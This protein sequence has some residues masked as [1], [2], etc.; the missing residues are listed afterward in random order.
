MRKGN[1]GRNVGLVCILFIMLGL[2]ATPLK[3]VTVYDPWNFVENFQAA[4]QAIEHNTNL[5]RQIQNQMTMISYEVQ[6]LR[7]LQASIGNTPLKS[8]QDL[9]AML[10][11]VQ[12]IG[13]T[14]QGLDKSYD[15]LYQKYSATIP[16]ACPDD[17]KARRLTQITA[18]TNANLDALQIQSGVVQDLDN[19]LAATNQVLMR[20][21]SAQGNLDVQQYGNELTAMQI[22]QQL[23]TQQ[24]LAVQNRLESTRLAEEQSR[25]YA[26]AQDYNYRMRDWGTQKSSATP[27]QDFPH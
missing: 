20:S 21:R 12:G 3:A 10:S 15:E 18:T 1:R 19:D 6:N 22:K 2:I 25:Q 14:V 16:G 9:D 7:A 24:L 8:V 13:Y 5:L 27:M 11:K 4:W 26:Q 23:K 17:I